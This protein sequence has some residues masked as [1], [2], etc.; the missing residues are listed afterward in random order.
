M[1]EHCAVVQRPIRLEVWNVEEIHKSKLV[2]P[3]ELLFAVRNDCITSNE[4]RLG[5]NQDTSVWDASSARIV[6]D[7]VYV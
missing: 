6:I 5:R 4:V 3:E 2:V 1:L 7:E